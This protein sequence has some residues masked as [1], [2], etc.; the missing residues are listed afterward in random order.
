LQHLYQYRT[1]SPIEQI[2]LISKNLYFYRA[3]RQIVLFRLHLPTIPFALVNRH[4]K[5]MRVTHGA[6]RLSR[7]N[8]RL[9][10]DESV[11]LSPVSGSHVN[12][13]TNVSAR[14]IKQTLHD[15]DR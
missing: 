3:S 14:A 11:L 4:V 8:A 12:T 2:S 1:T 9:D 15:V 5:T 10:N 6:G 13:I 7:I